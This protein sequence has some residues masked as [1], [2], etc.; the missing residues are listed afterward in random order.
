MRV[1]LI[2][3][4]DNQQLNTALSHCMQAAK[5]CAE[6][7]DILVVGSDCMQV[8]QAARYLGCNRVLLADQ[9]CYAEQ[10]AENTSALINTLASAYTH[11]MA[12]AS[13]FGRDLIPR[14]AALL[15]VAAISDVVRIID[16]QT[17]ERPIYAGNA[18]A[19]VKSWDP[20]KVMTVR[21]S[22]FEKSDA[23]NVPAPI[24]MIETA[25]A[26]KQI[27]V[28]HIEQI[29]SDRPPLSSARIVVSGGRGLQS[30]ANFDLLAQLADKLGA[31]MGATRAAVDAGFMPND[32]Q[33]GQTGK[34][35][36]PDLYIAVGI[37]GAIQH[38][39]GIKD[40]KVIV[41]INQD[42]QAPIFD[43]ADYALVGD[44]FDVIPKLVEI[45]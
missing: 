25:I 2:A 8:A 14:V 37:S 16:E 40:S 27:T 34:V 35:V 7:V 3:E 19:T 10:L 17:F 26:A 44:L 45:L 36:A 23:S 18:I 28:C 22:A 12:P 21:A 20:Q 30:Q 31:A 42:E 4:H 33:I 32:Y 38:I 39:A 11:I 41:A 6:Q 1:L 24:E 5:H 13:V 29:Q 15:D 9:A 43:I